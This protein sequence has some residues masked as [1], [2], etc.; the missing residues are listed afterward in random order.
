M[1]VKPARCLSDLAQARLIEL[2]FHDLSLGVFH[3]C[4]AAAFSLDGNK[5]AAGVP[6]PTVKM[7][8]PASAA[9]LAACIA[10]PLSSSP[11]VKMISARLPVADLPK[12][13]VARAIASEMLVPPSGMIFVSSSLI[14]STAAS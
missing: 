3:E 12:V 4:G 7:R 11:S 6:T 1:D 9:A 13:R 2:R 10:S 8:T 5:R 14:E